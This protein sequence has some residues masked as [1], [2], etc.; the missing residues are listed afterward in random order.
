MADVSTKDQVQLVAGGEAPSPAQVQGRHDDHHVPASGAG[1]EMDLAA[2]HLGHVHRGG[3]GV[4]RAVR[5]NH[6]AGTDAQGDILSGRIL[7][8]QVFLLLWGQF[9]LTLSGGDKVRSALLGKFGIK[10]VHLRCA[11]ESG[12]EEVGGMIENLLRRA[13]LLDET[14]LHDDN[15]VAQGHSLRLV[16]GDINKGGR[17]SIIPAQYYHGVHFDAGAA[18]AVQQSN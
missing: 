12:H 16:V 9:H 3:K 1:V 4:L 8:R 14:V 15:P 2:H 17:K 7:R 18:Y 6:V 13:H 5:E 10:K 11:D